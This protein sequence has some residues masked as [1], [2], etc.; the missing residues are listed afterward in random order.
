[1]TDWKI[2]PRARRCHACESDFADGQDYHSLLFDERQEYRRIDVCEDCWEGQ[3]G[4]G[5][6]DRKG[7]VSHWRSVFR[8]PPPPPPEPVA[9]E[10]AESALQR[11]S[12]MDRP[13]FRPLCYI[14]AAMLERKRI[15]RVRGESRDGAVRVLEYEHAKS[16]RNYSIHDPEL[17]LTEM[18]AV[19]EDV[20]RLLEEGV[21]AFLSAHA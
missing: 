7:F 11:L 8:L 13:D 3:Y 10:T 20:V 15:L 12:E 9:R 16:R 1:M 4:Q 14:L 18:E 6:R 19:Q 5:A 21:D 17:R 2:R